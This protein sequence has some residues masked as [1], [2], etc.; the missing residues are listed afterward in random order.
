MLS[1]SDVVK[2]AQIGLRKELTVAVIYLKLSEKFRKEDIAKKLVQFCEAEKGHAAFW[3]SFLNERKI[4]PD[5]VKVSQF[6]V[7]FLVFVYGLLGLGL[8]LKL[9]ESGERRVIEVFLKVS[10]SDFLS[11]LEKKNV[12]TFLLE[13]LDHEQEFVEYS[14]RYKIF[15]N[16]IGLIFSQTSDGLVIVLSTAIGL[17]GVYSR[18]VLIGIAGLIVGFA[19]TLSTV[20]GGLLFY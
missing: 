7:S 18:S 17:S 2:I 20:C 3:R 9:L 6:Q 1:D 16:K 4:S 19:A 12:K 10:K 14:A 15:I 8:T 5:N 13:E 11:P